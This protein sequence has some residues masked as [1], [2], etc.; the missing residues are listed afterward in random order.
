MSNDFQMVEE[1]ERRREEFNV[2]FPFVLDRERL[3]TSFS[4]VARD[5]TLEL[6]ASSQSL[7]G[8]SSVRA[9]STSETTGA[10]TSTTFTGA[11][12]KQLQLV[13]RLEKDT[14]VQQSLE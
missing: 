9:P 5:G 14:A 3:V 12:I 2:F 6:L 13:R 8:A 10:R 11:L 1:S 4:L 7:G